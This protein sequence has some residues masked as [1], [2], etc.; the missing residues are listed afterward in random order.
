MGE[1]ILKLHHVC[2]EFKLNK[3]ES[4]HAVRDVS[5]HV[6]SQEIVAVVGES[7]C[8]KSTLA[9]MIA[10]I[11]DV[12]SGDI[13]FQGKRINDIKGKEL[14]NYR[15]ELQMVFQDPK[16]VFSPR[17][18]IGD[19]LMEPWI[20]FEGLS[21]KEAEKEARYSLSRVGLG[22]ENWKKY[23]HQ[24]SGGELQRVAIARAI[25]LHPRLLICDEATSALD[26]STQKEILG[27]LKEHFDHSHM[28]QD[29]SVL[30]ITHDLA[31]A[32]NFCDRIVVMYLGRVVE[33]MKAHVLQLHARHPYTRAL[34]A[35]VFEI[36][37]D[38]EKP[39][40]VLQ[41]EAEGSR[42]QTGCIFCQRCPQ[43]MEICKREEPKLRKIRE[44]HY[45]ACHR[46]QRVEMK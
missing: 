14:R 20:N 31:L 46:E 9:R 44:G 39:I 13:F 3:N 27:L 18:K 11:E 19:F 36:Y 32:E 41:G 43:A 17:M 33:T 23:P 24:L 16:S 2:K 25:S 38:Q 30:F 45:L 34:L 21:K 4:L 40:E 5:F 6:S 10:R 26:V 7:G 29:F 37:E 28:G 35:S 1:E 42:E 15:K 12:S 22:E 8:G